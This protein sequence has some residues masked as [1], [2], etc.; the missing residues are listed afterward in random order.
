M[1]EF[2]LRKFVVGA[3]LM[4]TAPLGFAS[5]V[6]APTSM[7]EGAEFVRQMADV[8]ETSAAIAFWSGAIFFPVAVIAVMGLMHLLRRQDSKA[9]TIGGG[10]AI[11]GLVLNVTAFGAALVLMEVVYA[12]FTTAQKTAIVDLTI[13]SPGWFVPLA[14]VLLGA[15]GLL[16]LGAVLYR[17]ETIPRASAIALMAYGP[18]QLVGFG[19]EIIPFIVLSYVAMAVAFVPI[20]YT[21]FGET[22]EMWEQPP[23]FHGFR[24]AGA[25]R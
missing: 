1:Q 16:V 2:S 21:M 13:G 3:A 22:E 5:W 25:V 4:A 9:G 14:G 7:N 11:T 8:N 20:G 17:A 23:T 18:L 12:D 6:F 15:V 19:G 24:P 10:L